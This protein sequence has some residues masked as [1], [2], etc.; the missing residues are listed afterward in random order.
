MTQPS[1]LDDLPERKP[2]KRGRVTKTSVAA[3]RATPRTGRAAAVVEWLA[4]HEG[5]WTAAEV[6]S[7]ATRQWSTDALLYV[8]RGLSDALA[9]GLVERGPARECRIQGNR[10]V[11]WRIAHR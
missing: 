7:S 1:L 9:K 4:R 10:V 8:R 3:F 6:V 5:D 11:T 2:R